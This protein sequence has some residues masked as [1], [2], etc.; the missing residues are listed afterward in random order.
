MIGLKINKKDLKMNTL[1]V[2]TN[3]FLKDENQ[4]KQIVLE[5]TLAS[6]KLE[7]INISDEFALEVSQKVEMDIRKYN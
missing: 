7:G 1:I 2:E 3:E 4:R 6:F 5:S